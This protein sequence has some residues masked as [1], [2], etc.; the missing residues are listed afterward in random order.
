MR[1][2]KGHFIKGHGFTA[3]MLE[4]MSA[5]KLDKPTW[6]KGLCLSV[7]HRE[8]LSKARMGK[9][10]AN[11]GKPMSQ[12]L[13]DKLS[14]SKKGQRAWNKG[15][16]MSEEQKKKMSLIMKGRVSPN[17]GEKRSQ[18]SKNKMSLA[19]KGKPAW[20][21]GVKGMMPIPWNKGTKGLMK[22]PWN[23]GKKT[24]VN[25]HLRNGEDIPCQVCGKLFYA[26]PS[27]V[28]EGK[29]KFCSK[30][31]SNKGKIYK[32]IFQG[33]D[34]HPAWIDGQAGNGYPHEFSPALKRQ[35][36]LRDNYTCQLCGMTEA[37]HKKKFNRVLAVNHIDFD[38]TNCAI[39]NLNT[40]CT[41]CNTKVNWNRKHYT[42]YFK[43]LMKK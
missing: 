41:G 8:K 25:K 21:K 38:K 18:E 19:R 26:I 30:E 29:A 13:K 28:K 16:P 17:I 39:E 9:E 12:K 3:E 33:G 24:N 34:K 31:C 2:E 40:L 23:K 10:P 35:I 7:E 36:R 27:L 1:D 6:N 11:K 43:N 14:A 4:K 32:S 42:I 22:E 37:E 20:N 15:I 5:N